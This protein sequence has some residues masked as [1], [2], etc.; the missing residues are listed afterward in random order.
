MSTTK[1]KKVAVPQKATWNPYIR[2]YLTNV[3]QSSSLFMGLVVV[4]YKVFK[5]KN[6]Y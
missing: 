6:W 1:L 5:I 4:S 3:Y 2:I